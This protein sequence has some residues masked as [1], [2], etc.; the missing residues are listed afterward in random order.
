M[1]QRRVTQQ[2]IEVAE[3]LTGTD[4]IQRVTQ[5][6]MDVAYQPRPGGAGGKF[7]FVRPV[8]GR[9]RV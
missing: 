5:I 6:W 4:R 7:Q 1:A 9:H 8:L 3:Q 2:H